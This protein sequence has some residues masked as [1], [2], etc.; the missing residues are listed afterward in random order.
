MLRTI[1]TVAAIEASGAKIGGPAVKVTARALAK[2]LRVASSSTAWLRITAAEDFGAIEQDETQ[3]GGRGGARY[4][5]VLIGSA[6]IRNAPGFGVF[7][8]TEHVVACMGGYPPAKNTEP[9]PRHGGK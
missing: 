4:F 5:K 3:G 2:K 6:S 7:P 8:P 1:A 9:K